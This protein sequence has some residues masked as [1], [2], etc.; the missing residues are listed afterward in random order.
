[1]ILLGGVCLSLLGIGDRSMEAATGPQ[2]V[3]YRA[4]GQAVFFSVMFL[5]FRKRSIRD[6]VGSLTARGWMASGLM[7]FAGFFLIMSIQFT[8]IANA[9]FIISLTPLIAAALAW[10]FLKERINRRT[11]IAMLIAVIGVSIISGTNVDPQGMVG[12]AFAG[13]MALCYASV[14]VIMRVIP[15]AN[16]TLMCAVSGFLTILLML[17]VVETFSISTHDLLI[18]LAMGC[19]QVGLG[20]VLVMTGAQNVPAAQVSILALLEVVLGPIWVWMFVNEIPALTTLLGGAIVMAG[21]I[22]QALGA[23]QKRTPN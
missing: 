1:M 3:L 13:A 21:V 14:L 17:P 19:F 8:L 9:V 5:I 11:G 12:M 6:E 2:I 20:T 4:L 23:R 22:Y 18:C 7:A 16:V 15:G 10:I